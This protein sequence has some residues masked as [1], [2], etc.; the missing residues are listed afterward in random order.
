MTG[1]PGH[2]ISAIALPS[3]LP[4]ELLSPIGRSVREPLSMINTGTQHQATGSLRWSDV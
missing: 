1:L 4:R 2:R 3:H